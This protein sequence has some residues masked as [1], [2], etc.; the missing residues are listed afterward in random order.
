MGIFQGPEIQPDAVGGFPV[1]YNGNIS[2]A[3][4]TT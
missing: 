4:N 3:R 1:G 2:G